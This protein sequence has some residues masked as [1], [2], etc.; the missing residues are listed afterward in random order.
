MDSPLFSPF[1]SSVQSPES[2][3]SVIALLS[4]ELAQRERRIVDQTLQISERDKKIVNQNARI[5]YLNQRVEQLEH[6]I[7]QANDRQFG[8]SNEQRA[9]ASVR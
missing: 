1:L 6:M 5:D 2:L 7:R 9:G 3:A 4:K 8:V